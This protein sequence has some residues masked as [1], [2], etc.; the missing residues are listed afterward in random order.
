MPLLA[1]HPQAFTQVAKGLA[2]DYIK[3]AEA[4]DEGLLAAVAAALSTVQSTATG[5]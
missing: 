1:A 5:E 3:H 4:L 2:R